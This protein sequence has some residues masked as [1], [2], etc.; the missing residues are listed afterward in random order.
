[1]TQPR[2]DQSG[3]APAGVQLSG[4]A[5]RDRARRAVRSYFES[6]DFLE[7]ETPTFTDCPG[8]DPHVHSLGSVQS[9]GAGSSPG[10]IR[11]PGAEVDRGFLITS[12]EFHMKRLLA[13][14]MSRIYQLARCFRAE[15]QGPWHEPEFTLLEWYRAPGGYEDVLWDTERIIRGVAEAIRGEPVLFVPERDGGT[16]RLSVSGSFLR[17]TVREAFARFGGID[18]AVALAD[19]DEDAFFQIL[20]D[21]VEPGLAALERPVFL[22]HYPASQASL[23]RLSPDDPTV[24]ERFECYVGGVELSNGFGELTDPIEQRRRFEVERQRRAEAGEPLY[25]L[26]ERFLS[27]LEIGLPDCA[28]NALGFDRLVALAVEAQDIQSV[29]A[30]PDRER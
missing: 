3:G 2:S 6:Q 27:A 14:G 5:A 21:R 20:V 19:R 15:E 16:R 26:P 11:A 28:G 22:T 13:Q 8:L 4:L 18:D 24:S 7:V 25:P 12:P 29:M 10:A 1:M 23:A 17:L 30:F 9:R